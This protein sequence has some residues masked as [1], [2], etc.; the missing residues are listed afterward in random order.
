MNDLYKLKELFPDIIEQAVPDDKKSNFY[1]VKKYN[2][3]LYDKLL[4]TEGMIKTDL[5]SCA[6]SVRDTFAFFLQEAF[7]GNMKAIKDAEN[8]SYG[9]KVT[10]AGYLKSAK[11][12][13]E[14]HINAGDGYKVKDVANAGS[15]RQELGGDDSFT[16]E[17]VNKKGMIALHNVLKQYYSEKYPRD[18]NFIRNVK[19]R[20]EFQPINSMIV[21]DI[22]QVGTSDCEAQYLCFS[23]SD[24]LINY[25]VVRQYSS[26]NRSPD[27]K[28]DEEV[29]Q[30]LWRES[31]RNPQ[32]I[33]KYEKIESKQGSDNPEDKK[34]FICYEM[35]GK[36]VRLSSKLIE[37]WDIKTKLAIL[38][39]LTEGIVEIH[40]RKI[41]HRNLQPNAVYVYRVGDN[42]G[43]NLVNFEFSKVVGSNVTVFPSA[44]KNYYDDFIFTPPELRGISNSH[45]Y[46]NV[47]WEKADIFSLGVLYCYILL[48]GNFEIRGREVKNINVIVNKIQDPNCDGLRDLIKRMC[49]NIADNRPDIIEVFNILA[50]FHHL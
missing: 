41:Y 24:N 4:N 3:E 23:E 30:K 21:Y 48:N 47:D 42:V 45:E 10:I 25:Y 20:K 44:S 29:L 12:H 15:H 27:N 46:V 26:V 39:L 28:R 1:F 2:P 14:L 31:I 49:N 5:V 8:A 13:P 32:G 18:K 19:Y 37:K 9:N 17:F 43:I 34:V 22:E 36:P 16:Y 11:M 6:K 35:N 40:N 38:Q 50:T 7:K 33:V